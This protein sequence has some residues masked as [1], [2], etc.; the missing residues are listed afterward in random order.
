[1]TYESS[2]AE[3]GRT[4]AGLVLRINGEDEVDGAAVERGSEFL[5]GVESMFDVW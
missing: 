4:R 2:L 3:E 5:V 1:M